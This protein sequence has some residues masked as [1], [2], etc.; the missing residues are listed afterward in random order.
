VHAQQRVVLQVDNKQFGASELH[1][2][3]LLISVQ[4]CCFML[5]YA[6]GAVML[7][8]LSTDCVSK[9]H[10]VA[11]LQYL[12]SRLCSNAEAM[13]GTVYANEEKSQYIVSVTYPN[14]TTSVTDVRMAAHDG[15]RLSRKIGSACL[16]HTTQRTQTQAF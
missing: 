8:Q 15:T 7:L 10:C 6:S 3:V 16:A 14:S 1:S 4:S 13:C 5:S 11:A 2:L 12:C 9:I